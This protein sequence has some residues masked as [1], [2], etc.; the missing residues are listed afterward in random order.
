MARGASK[1]KRLLIKNENDVS[2]YIYIYIYI[3]MRHFFMYVHQKRLYIKKTSPR[4]W[5][6]VGSGA[7]VAG[8]DQ[9][10]EPAEN[11]N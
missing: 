11:L 8:W 9:N 7:Y 5:R 4:P 3:H 2:I 1:K 6:L 10:S